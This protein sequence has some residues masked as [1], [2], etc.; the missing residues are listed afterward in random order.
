MDHGAAMIFKERLDEAVHVQCRSPL[1]V[2]LSGLDMICSAAMRLL[3]Q[4]Q[5]RLEDD[6]RKMVTVGLQG[7]ARETVEMCGM[8]TLL[9][10]APSI[11]T[12]TGN[13]R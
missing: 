9:A 5:R 7:A 12:V 4:Y 11:E 10:T 13:T 6:G 3:V 1:I 8:D 2:D